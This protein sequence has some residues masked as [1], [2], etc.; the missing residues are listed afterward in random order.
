MDVKKTVF[1]FSGG[2]QTALEQGL[3]KYVYAKKL[4]NAKEKIAT[5]STE[6]G[7]NYYG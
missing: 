7:T 1:C 3:L 4:T 2:L 5:D 6:K